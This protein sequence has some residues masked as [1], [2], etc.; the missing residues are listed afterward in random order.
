MHILKGVFLNPINIL[1]VA[2]IASITYF[3]WKPITEMMIRGDGLVYL[4]N[5]VQVNNWN[6]PVSFAGLEVG[7]TFLS[8]F[9][10]PMFGINIQYYFWVE[11]IVILGINILFFYMVLALTKNRLIAFTAAFLLCLNYFGNWEMYAGG[12]YAYFMDR[13]PDMLFLIPSFMCLHLFLEQAKYKYYLASLL[14]YFLGVFVGHWSFIFTGLY[15]FYPFFWFLFKEK[16]ITTNGIRIALPYLM[17]TVFFAYL[18]KGYEGGLGPNWTFTEFLLNPG[19]YKYP[20]KLLRQLTY[21]SEYIVVFKGFFTS[22][23]YTST[24]IHYVTDIRN[25]IAIQ[26]YVTA[27]Y[28]V[29]AVAVFKLLPKLRPLLFTLIFATASMFYLNSYIGQYQIFT[30]PASNRYLYPPSFLLTI[31]WALVLY[32]VFWRSLKLKMV[33]W[34]ILLLYFG[35]NYILIST[36]FSWLMERH[37][38]TKMVWYKAVEVGKVAKD[39]T[40]ILIPG[41]ETGKYEAEFLNDHIGKE[42][43]IF[44]SDNE[45]ELTKMASE[46][47]NIVRVSYDKNCNCAVAH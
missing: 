32:A 44:I 9:M 21:W 23:R 14:L 41:F 47:A 15:L 30:E 40:A 12:I 10:T 38:P 46:S 4:V 11:L 17:I 7:S 36:H 13:M 31:F 27:I 28:I 5:R 35:I 20:E 42:R 33:F 34:G 29:A 26:P 24:P 19:Q 16:K 25:A 2:I 8:M 37:N 22:L 3:I 45:D 6:P 1:S 18:Q 43:V 39:D